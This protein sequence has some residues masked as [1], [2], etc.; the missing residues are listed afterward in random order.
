MLSPFADD[1]SLFKIIRAAQRAPSVFNTQPWSF[2]VRADDRIELRA[3]TSGADHRHP[4]RWLE[5][6]DP[7]S[8]ELAISC[9]AA[10]FNLRMAIRVT[11]HGLAAWLVPDPEDD[12][13]LLASVEI[14]TGRVRSPT[15]E[16]QEL[17]DAI[18]NRHTY[19]WPFTGHRVRASILT[20][21]ERTA[22]KERAYL[23]VLYP[24]Q[25]TSWLHAAGDAE[26][27]FIH[28]ERY[29]AEL[30]RWTSG[31]EPGLGVPKAAYGP[32]PPLQS[33]NPPVRDF[34]FDWGDG[35]PVEKFESHPQLLSLATDY[36]RPLDWLRAGQALQ[37][38]LLVATRYGVAASFLTQSLE[39]A[40]HKHERRGWPGA[41][42]FKET[43]QM[44]IRVGYPDR[45]LP[46]TPREEFPDVVD[47]RGS[48]PRRV[49]PPGP[50]HD[51]REVG[52]R[53]SPRGQLPG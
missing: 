4:D 14:V 15:G 17:Y 28:D 48:T 44:L 39:L 2:W 33:M 12:P 40:D 38:A 30:R 11:G 9:G 21:L 53:W 49:R 24:F 18:P 51:R 26:R 37:R 5:V 25:A 46:V 36:D 43:P 23:R 19:R 32:Q 22:A 34:G 16:E 41:W 35:R 10:L 7:V 20:E 13:T 3:N 27:Q 6:T 47:L 42:T 8:R 52:S 31:A 1:R 50:D 45:R 29:L